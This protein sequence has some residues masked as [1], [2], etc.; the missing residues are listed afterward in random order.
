[1][2]AGRPVHPAWCDN[3][4]CDAIDPA[5]PAIGGQHRSAVEQRPV[6][7]AAGGRVLVSMQLQQPGAVPV[8]D[9]T[10]VLA[11]RIGEGP[12]TLVPLDQVVQV[13]DA[14]LCLVSWDSALA[15]WLAGAAGQ[16]RA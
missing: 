11:I 4:Y 13:L 9:P 16:H 3:R 6:I 1:M 15:G 2:T 7:T 8:G 14:L 10:P 5:L 12:L